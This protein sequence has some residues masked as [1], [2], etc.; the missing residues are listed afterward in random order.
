M[1]LYFTTF[2]VTVMLNVYFCPSVRLSVYLSVQSFNL[3]CPN[4]GFHWCQVYM[5]VLSPHWLLH[6][7]VAYS[8]HAY[9][10]G[11]AVQSQTEEVKNRTCRSN[12]NSPPWSD[13]IKDG[14]SEPGGGK[15][16]ANISILVI[17]Y[18]YPLLPSDISSC[19][20]FIRIDFYPSGSEL[21]LHTVKI[22]V[23]H[24]DNRWWM[25]KDRRI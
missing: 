7:L 24:Y 10:S 18:H 8:M 2:L 22:D 6:S 17:Y 9:I 20:L 15:L 5:V 23:L 14:L 4:E 19:L 12:C 3:H 13:V 21:Y 25:K 11:D 1:N 16:I